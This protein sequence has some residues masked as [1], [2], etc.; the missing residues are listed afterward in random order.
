MIAVPASFVNS[1]LDYLNKILGLSYRSKLTNYFH[2]KYV[3]NMIFYQ[4]SNLDSRVAN[5]DQRLTSDIDKWAQSYSVI[6]SN[7]TKPVLDIILFSKKLADLIGPHGPLY[8][9]LWYFCSGVV[10][11]LVSPPFGR[12]TAV[13]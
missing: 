4:V 3:K 6:Y 13:D 1:Y 11:K 5:P 9:F 12:M 7:F 2:E 10:L 8:V